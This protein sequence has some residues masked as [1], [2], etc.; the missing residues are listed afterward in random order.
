MPQPLAP[1]RIAVIA[2]S[3]VSMFNLAIPEMLFG[4]VEVDGRP[5]YEVII[6]AAE[7]GP[8]PTSGGLDLYVRRG[9]DATREADTVVVAGT[10]APYEPD[11]RIVAAVKE[12]AA[13]GK[14]VASLCTG[15]FQLAE[16]GLLAG[17][18]ATTYWAH[19]E[20]LRRRY[21]QV[22]LQGDV[23]YVQ[24]GP[25]VTS[26]GYAAGIDLCLHVIRT[27]YG[28]AVANEVARRALVA[29]VRPGGQTQFTHTPLP[30]E[31]GNACADTRGWAMR[32]LDKPLSLTD[33]A[34][35][36]G[37]S[38]RTL[39]RRFHAESGVSPLQWLLHQRIERAK[40]LLETTTLPMDQVAR[41]C[42]L[43]T[44]DS[45][46]AHVVRRTGLTPSAYRTQFS[47][48]GTAASADTSSAA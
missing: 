23:L 6:C 18:R 38:V 47:R 19:A 30:P 39:T 40:E 17:R 4:K 11:P 26:S 36:A 10:G 28:A 22:D 45:L 25:Y 46:R 33:L 35:H 2:P 13:D 44:A 8:V 14:R 37:V 29:P 5:G 27:D 15:A 7:P 9:L 42:G 3:P 1:H 24:D 16:A 20:E 48:L 31:R 21:P 41:A 34:R 32:H 43:G 12:A